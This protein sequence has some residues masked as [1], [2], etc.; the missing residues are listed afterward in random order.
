MFLN[1]LK[2]MNSI[3]WH[4]ISKVW[5]YILS[6]IV[7]STGTFL[8]VKDF[9]KEQIK[10]WDEGSSAKNA[11]DMLANG[12]FFIQYDNGQPVRDDYKP[13]LNLW[14]KMAGYKVF[15]INEFSVR[16]PSIVAAALTMLLLWYFGAFML[17]KPLLGILMPLVLVCS[18]GYVFYHVAR[19]GDPDSLLIL[20]TTS[21]AIS[22]F[23]LLMDFGNSHNKHL[24]L[25]GISAFL[26]IFTKGIMGLAPLV[27]FA[28]FTF[29][30]KDGIRLLKDYRIYL[31]AL[32]VL[33]LS[34]IYYVG[35]EIADPG[36]L[37][38]VWKYEIFAFKKYPLG[39]EKHPEFIFYFKH[40][41]NNGF[42]PFFYL[43]P[44]AIAALFYSKNSVIRMLIAYSLSGS[45][46][47]L[48][49]MSFAATKNEWYISAVYPILAILVATGI[50]SIIMLVHSLVK[51]RHK[52]L[53]YI[54]TTLA[55]ILLCWRP[56]DKIHASNHSYKYYTYT[57]ERAGRFLKQC[58]T[59]MPEL[60][61]IDVIIKHHPR[62]IKF[63]EKKYKYEDGTVTNICK[64]IP[65][66]IIGRYVLTCDEKTIF[67][68][69]KNYKTT[70]V[71][72][73]KYCR[74]IRVD[75]YNTENNI[76]TFFC[77]T[78]ILTNDSLHFMDT[79]NSNITFYNG[80]LTRSAAFSGKS[81]V[82]ATQENPFNLTVNITPCQH[83]KAIKA[84]VWRKSKNQKGF[85]VI[86]LPEL[87]INEQ[88]S[89]AIKEENGWEKLEIKLL[90]PPDSMNLLV[91]VYVWNP[92]STVAYFDD[93]EIVVF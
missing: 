38:G 59:D 81:S 70:T 71:N 34:G 47:F 43:I 2:P 37:E 77:N 31:V 46:V 56:V 83:R 20:F 88:T 91:K 58:K 14:L 73:D 48:T 72:H 10:I 84:R 26:A 85:L 44:L 24:W 7:L 53:F 86:S 87:D 25:L 68:I 16:L 18:R 40:L 27:G 49:I 17:K 55:L 90:L 3:A 51:D 75:G 89:Q 52:K 54:L 65:N 93:L 80:G 76:D 1:P 79:Q 13:P 63:Y 4:S 50:H 62:Q 21:A 19:T 45:I 39:N 9:H 78:E 36:Y 29:I 82:V 28:I 33:F 57:P 8:I 15:G 11:I 6:F 92:N 23:M 12:N 22:Y 69:Y 66:S 32:G 61:E 60:K 35:R 5:F 41:I 30:T 42:K 74:L 67:D 64:E